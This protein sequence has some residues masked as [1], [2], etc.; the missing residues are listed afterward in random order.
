MQR[1]KE[2]KKSCARLKKEEKKDK[3]KKERRNWRDLQNKGA[4]KEKRIK[5][6]AAPKKQ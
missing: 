5:E 3:K 6:V 1:N 2:K 4:K